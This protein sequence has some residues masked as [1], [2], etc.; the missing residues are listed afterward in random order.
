MHF[1]YLNLKRKKN[2]ISP[3]IIDELFFNWLKILKNIISLFV[4]NYLLLLSRS[5]A[6][7]MFFFLFKKYFF[8]KYY[9]HFIVM[10][11]Y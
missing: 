10:Q 4:I 9:I 1:E 6:F 11:I 8:R 3:Y 7:F 2:I 5:H